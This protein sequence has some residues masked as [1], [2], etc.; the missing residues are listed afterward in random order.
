MK[1]LLH[2]PLKSNIIL[3][4]G[5]VRHMIFLNSRRTIHQAL[6]CV[7][8]P[9][10]AGVA[11]LVRWALCAAERTRTRLLLSA[12]F[13]INLLSYTSPQTLQD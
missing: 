11:A 10:A 6:V 4:L 7:I 3:E 5:R 13:E 9:V 1:A 8:L 2:Q 12:V